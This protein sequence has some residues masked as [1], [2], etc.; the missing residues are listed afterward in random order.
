MPNSRCHRT[1]TDRQTQDNS[2]PHP[3]LFETPRPS[4]QATLPSSI[5]S[6]ASSLPILLTNLPIDKLTT[7]LLPLQLPLPLSLAITLAIWTLLPLITLTT[8][9]PLNP[10]PTLN[11]ISPRPQANHNF[12]PDLSN[13]VHFPSW[14]CVRCSIECTVVIAGC[15]VACVLPDPAQPALCSVSFLSFSSLRF[16][17]IAIFS[18]AGG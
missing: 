18:W 14:A 17:F 5:L 9:S 1:P 10:P 3:L 15:T 12:P 2:T 13:N 8:A 7:M 16:P 11:I 4:T 6:L